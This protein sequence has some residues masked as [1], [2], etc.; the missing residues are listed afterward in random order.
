M[1]SKSSVKGTAQWVTLLSILFH[2]KFTSY[3]C[4]PKRK[5]EENDERQSGEKFCNLTAP[6]LRSCFPGSQTTCYITQWNISLNV[7]PH[8]LGRMFS[9]PTPKSSFLPLQWDK[10]QY[11]I[12][13]HSC[14]C[15]S[16]CPLED[17]IQW[18]LQTKEAW[19]SKSWEN[20]N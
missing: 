10:N 17:Y 13:P 3:S 16:P 14:M 12:I 20:I 19:C 15:P 1:N 4:G 7:H 11:P 8:E 9:F 6:H 2:P 18:F 5:A